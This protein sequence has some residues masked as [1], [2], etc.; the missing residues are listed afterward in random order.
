MSDERG[1]FKSTDSTDQRKNDNNNNNNNNNDI[2]NNNKDEESSVADKARAAGAY[3]AD[4]VVAAKDKVVELFTPTKDKS[5]EDN[6]NDDATNKEPEKNTDA[7][8]ELIGQKDLLRNQH[9]DGGEMRRG[10]GAGLDDR[11][12]ER[13]SGL[14][15][16]N[17]RP[18]HGDRLN[19]EK[20]QPRGDKAK[21]DDAG[22]QGVGD[23]G[24]GA[25]KSSNIGGGS[26]PAHAG[27]HSQQTNEQRFGQGQQPTAAAGGFGSEQRNA[28][29]GNKPNIGGSSQHDVKPS[30]HQGSADDKAHT[31]RTGLDEQSRSTYV[32]DAR[33]PGSHLPGSGSASGQ[34]KPGMNDRA[35][36]SGES[37]NV[38]AGSKQDKAEL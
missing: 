16:D 7:Q 12:K 31:A 13:G 33:N 6:R 34:A 19:E 27:K 36:R 37:R 30:I 24:P 28:I 4:S 11:T 3:I 8:H 14:R 20:Q 5:T 38:T 35:Q 21:P 29:G 9:K 2:D 10:D 22:L 25:Y 23:T 26:H 17:D 18:R 32:G 15:S 1:K